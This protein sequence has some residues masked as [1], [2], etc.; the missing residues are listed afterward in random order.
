MTIVVV[1]PGK[2][3]ELPDLKIAGSKD[4]YPQFFKFNIFINQPKDRY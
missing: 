4:S 3:A 1:P 2:E